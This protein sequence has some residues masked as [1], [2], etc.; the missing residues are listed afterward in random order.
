MITAFLG[1]SLGLF[2]FLADGLKFNKAGIQGK[3]T[4]AL[5]FLPPL[6]VVLF[7]PGIYLNALSYAGVCCVVLL[8]LL[9]TLM[10]WK[11]RKACL[12]PLTDTQRMLPGGSLALTALG[13]IGCGL[14]IIAAYY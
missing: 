7:K 10:A 11:G 3:Y 9:P 13:F 1:V 14:L 6:T 2:D 4:L 5:T 12:H 8:V